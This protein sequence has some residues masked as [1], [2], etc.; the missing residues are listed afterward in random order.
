M[1]H[2]DIFQY[3]KDLIELC[4]STEMSYMH[5]S[6]VILEHIVNDSDE[7]QD[8]STSSKERLSPEN[9]F[10]NNKVVRLIAVERTLTTG[11]VYV[12]SGLN[13][14]FHFSS[15]TVLLTSLYEAIQCTNN[16]KVELTFVPRTV[17]LCNIEGSIKVM[18]NIE[19]EDS[20]IH[21]E[22][23]DIHD[24]LVGKQSRNESKPVDGSSSE[25]IKDYH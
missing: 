16:P 10:S 2:S 17:T 12:A 22:C 20:S 24:A 6:L 5:Q 9:F 18:N 15:P 19:F 1:P 23:R 3:V 8:A 14:K 13:M 25:K 4:E 21:E 11:Q 7:S